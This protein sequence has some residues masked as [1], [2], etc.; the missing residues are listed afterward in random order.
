MFVLG[1]IEFAIVGNPNEA[2]VD[3]QLRQVVIFRAHGNP[4]KSNPSFAP[5]YIDPGIARRWS[6]KCEKI[7]TQFCT[8][9]LEWKPEDF[10]FVNLNAL[11]FAFTVYGRMNAVMF[12][13]RLPEIFEHA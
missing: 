10:S 9:E 7:L 3:N 12:K 2:V 8:Q 4:P 1:P 5:N 13:L 11:D 6:D